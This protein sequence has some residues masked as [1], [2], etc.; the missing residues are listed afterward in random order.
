VNGPCHDHLPPVAIRRRDEASPSM[1]LEPSLPGSHSFFT[2]GRERQ[3]RLKTNCKS[4]KYQRPG[5]GTRG[6]PLFPARKNG[7]QL[8]SGWRGTT[9]RGHLSAREAPSSCTCLNEARGSFRAWNSLFREGRLRG[10]GVNAH[11]LEH[12]T[13]KLSWTLEKL[14]LFFYVRDPRGH[15]E[16]G[17]GQV[18]GEGPD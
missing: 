10:R 15:V 16:C 2:C 1:G 11:S 7:W 6:S 3:P 18:L 12:Y 17:R 5:K 14:K 9:T 4:F 8:Q 13:R